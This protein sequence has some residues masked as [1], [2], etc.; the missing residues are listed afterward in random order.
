[1]QLTEQEFLK[2][3]NNKCFCGRT[4]EKQ[5][6]PNKDYI[7]ICY[8]KDSDHDFEFNCIDN[9]IMTIFINFD[10][11][12][13]K[14]QNILTTFYIEDNIWEFFLDNNS[15]L[16][17]EIDAVKVLNMSLEELKNKVKTIVNFN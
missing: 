5:L 16:Y 8:Y 11:L 6:L 14:N 10:N 12:I 1:M 13:Q 15:D 2:K 7:Y 3:F 4:L 17:I 9:H